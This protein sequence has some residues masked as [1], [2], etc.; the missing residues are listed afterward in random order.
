MAPVVM[1]LP[2]NAGDIRASVRSLV[3]EIP[4]R[5]AWQL[6]PIFLPGIFLPILPIDRGAW[7]ATVHKVAESDTT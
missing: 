7:W 1:N 4:W 6:T 5:R 2:V 3:G